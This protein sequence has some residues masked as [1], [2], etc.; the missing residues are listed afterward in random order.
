MYSHDG[1]LNY[2]NWRRVVVVLNPDNGKGPTGVGASI[3]RNLDLWGLV[4]H[5][6][7]NKPKLSVNPYVV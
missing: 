6:L 3:A 4:V 7:K 2:A 1:F 5:L